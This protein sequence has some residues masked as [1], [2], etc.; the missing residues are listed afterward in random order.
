M[1]FT[2]NVL[3]PRNSDVCIGLIVCSIKPGTAENLKC[4]V[5][6][7]GLVELRGKQVL[8]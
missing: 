3:K 5:Q 7:T 4:F 8:I 6:M 1:V 2:D